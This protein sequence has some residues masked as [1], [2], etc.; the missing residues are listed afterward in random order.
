MKLPTIDTKKI[1]NT[2]KALFTTAMWAGFIVVSFFTA[3]TLRADID[4][5]PIADGILG[6]IQGAFGLAALGLI[7]FEGQ[8]N[9]DK[10]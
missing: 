5:T 9:K 10:K 7:I 6:S 4:L 1:W 3:L 2:T 8:K